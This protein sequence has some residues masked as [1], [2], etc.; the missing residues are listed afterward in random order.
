M[1]ATV[2]YLGIHWGPGQ[3]YA[4]PKEA[5][6]SPEHEDFSENNDPRLLFS[7]SH[8]SRR[9]AQAACHSH[10]AVCLSI[11]EPSLVLLNGSGRGY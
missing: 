3:A 9:F 7:F 2:K 6:T 1:H 5:S 8:H 11:N 4:K 10:T